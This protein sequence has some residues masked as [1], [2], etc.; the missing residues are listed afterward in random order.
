MTGVAFAQDPPADPPAGGGVDVDASAGANATVG[1]DGVA[2]DANAAVSVTGVFTLANWPLSYVTRPQ[3]I[4]KGGIELSP[5][6]QLDYASGPDGM[7]GDTSSTITSIGIGGRY[8]VTDKVEILASFAP[9][10]LTGVEGIEAGDR[11]KGTVAAGVGL[12]LAQGKLD[13]EAKAALAYD[14]GGETAAILAGVDVRFN[15]G[16]KMW[17]GTPI[18]RP[19]LVAF[20]KGFDNGMGGTISPIFF[21]LPAAFAFQATP[22]LAFQANTNIFTVAFNDGGKLFTGG[23]SVSFLFTDEGGGL[24]LDFDVIFALSN[25][26]D[27]QANLD[28]GDVLNAGDA[29]SLSAGIN[30]RL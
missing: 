7:G 18:N 14:L 25:T 17:L 8:G 16:P 22:A 9:I 15:L 12:G 3:V 26:M 23:E 5:R 24:P 30:L 11:V 4:Y 27:V 10:I 28:L 13:A 1:T 19:G 2:V 29:F 20:V 21:Q 6:F